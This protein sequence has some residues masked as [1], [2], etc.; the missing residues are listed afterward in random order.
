MFLSSNGRG[1]VLV[2]VCYSENKP[3]NPRFDNPC[4]LKKCYKVPLPSLANV[5][6]RLICNRQRRWHC[7]RCNDQKVSQYFWSQRG[8]QAFLGR[9]RCLGE[10]SGETSAGVPRPQRWRVPASP[11][12]LAGQRRS[13]VT[14]WGHVIKVCLSCWGSRSVPLKHCAWAW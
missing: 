10:G 6:D 1:L 7:P 4:I 12:C 11:R 8:T 2:L 5:C 13:R 3:Q 9:T 14:D